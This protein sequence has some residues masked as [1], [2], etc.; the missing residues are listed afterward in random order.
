LHLACFGGHVALAALLIDKYRADLTRVNAWACGVAH[1]AAMADFKNNDN[2]KA[3][4]M[5]EFLKQRGV[6]MHL[7]QREG[8]TPAHKA[9]Q[10]LNGDVLRWLIED[11]DMNDVV[12]NF[13]LV[14]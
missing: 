10:R 11:S 1:W 9:A 3:V 14:V 8:H 12:S 7:P 2:N 6:A 4:A 13:V 5:C